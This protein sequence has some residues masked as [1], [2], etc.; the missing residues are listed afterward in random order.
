[1]KTLWDKGLIYEG[2]RVLPYS[3]ALETPLSNS[4]TR[5]DDAYKM[6]QDPALTVGFVLESGD[7][8]LAW[9]TT[10]WTLPSN[11]AL[12]VAPDVDYVRVRHNDKVYVLAEARLA[13]YAKELDG[14]EVLGT[15]RGS[16]LVGQRY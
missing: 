16:G 15:V 13:A 1:F 8:L 7:N 2:F 4:E 3:W 11:L 6:V 9:T 5:M 10:P 14:A 12:A